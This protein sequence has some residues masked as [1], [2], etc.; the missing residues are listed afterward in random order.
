MKAKFKSSSVSETREIGKKLIEL[1]KEKFGNYG[2]VV[3]LLIGQLGTGK[4]E[5]VKGIAQGM[6]LQKE[7]VTS[8]TFSIIQ[9][10]SPEKILHVD[11]YR[12]DEDEQSDIL[13]VV[14]EKLEQGYL[15]VIEWGE[16]IP[17]EF[18]SKKVFVKIDF[19]EGENEREIEI[20]L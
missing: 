8:P 13:A 7:L 14:S 9:E 18:F 10:Y 19:G 1:I 11:M 2:G 20:S 17:H 4:T 12:I 3:V 15:A 6:G 5:M 16:K